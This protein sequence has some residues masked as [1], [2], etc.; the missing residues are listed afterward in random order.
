MSGIAGIR[1]DFLREIVKEAVAQKF[2]FE[3]GGKHPVLVC[4]VCGHRETI[5]ASGKQTF[6]ESRN[7]VCRLRRHGLLWKG[8]GGKH[9]AVHGTD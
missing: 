7:K 2:A 1:S 4:P 3:W 6:H 5:T 8:I 9:V